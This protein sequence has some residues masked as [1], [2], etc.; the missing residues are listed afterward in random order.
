MFEIVAST[1]RTGLELN[2]PSE[3]AL[4]AF[5]PLVG[6]HVGNALTLDVQPVAFGY[7]LLS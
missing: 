7:G 1:C 6:L 2:P 4:L 3:E 5:L